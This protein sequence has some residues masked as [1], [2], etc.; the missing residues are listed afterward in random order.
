MREATSAFLLVALILPIASVQAICCSI[1]AN[2]VCIL[3]D[4][5]R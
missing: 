3:E 2:A 1:V 4:L 5:S